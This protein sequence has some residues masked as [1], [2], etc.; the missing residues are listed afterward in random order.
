MLPK[1]NPKPSSSKT[2]LTP[3]YEFIFHLVKSQKY[4]YNQLRTPLSNKTKSSHP[5]RHRNLIKDN[6]NKYSPYIPN[7]EGKNIED[8]IDGDVIHTAVSNQSILR[9]YGI[10]H[11]APFP[12]E[13]VILPILQTTRENDIVLDVFSGTGVVGDECFKMNRIYYGIDIN[14]HFINLQKKKFD[15]VDTSF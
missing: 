4:Y 3:S 8:Y 10:E 2:N 12:N 13:I 1:K 11:P 9:N 5:P 14:N 7:P 6:I 15:S